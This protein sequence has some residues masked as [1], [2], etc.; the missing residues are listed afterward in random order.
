MVYV[1]GEMATDRQDLGAPL[2][3][4]IIDPHLLF[5]EALTWALNEEGGIE[6]PGIATTGDEGLRQVRV[7]GPELVVLDIRLPSIEG[8]GVGTRILQESPATRIL[9]L[10]ES[11]DVASVREAINSGFH[12]Y[13]TKSVPM[14]Q[15]VNA[16]RTICSG[17]MVMPQGLAAPVSMVRS[18]EEEYWFLKAR[19]MTG[20]ER[21]VLRLLVEGANSAEIAKRLGI[22]PNTVRTHIQSLLAKL[23]VHSRLQAAM[24]A[25]H[26]RFFESQGD[27]A[28]GSPPGVS[29]P[30]RV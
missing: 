14:S 24:Q 23:Q 26:H 6:V 4:L 1:G 7:L 20:R 18:P 27:F 11:D 8:T 22:R 29:R 19:L 5:A 15:L 21:D 2:R 28:E 10:S 30:A 17:Q 9:A 3:V 13:L 25:R 16:I 12:G